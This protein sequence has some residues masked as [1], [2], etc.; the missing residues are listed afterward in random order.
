MNKFV[1]YPHLKYHV[2][3]ILPDPKGYFNAA[4]VWRKGESKSGVWDRSCTRNS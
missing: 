2:I 3:L 1:V 4:G